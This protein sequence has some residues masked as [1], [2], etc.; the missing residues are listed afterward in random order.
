MLSHKFNDPSISP[1]V[2]PRSRTVVKRTNHGHV[3]KFASQKCARIVQ[4]ESSLE[5]DLAI[6]LEADP[7][8]ILFYEQPFELQIMLD[9]KIRTVYPDMMVFQDDG[10]TQVIEVKPSEKASQPKTRKKF[11]LEHQALVSMGYQFMVL[12]ENYI[13]NGFRL[14]NSRKLLPFR[15]IPVGTLLKETVWSALKWRPMS[16]KE[17]L[18]QINGLTFE[19]LFALVSHGV[20]STDLSVELTPQSLFSPVKRHSQ[21]TEQQK[22]IWQRRCV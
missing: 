14:P 17:M 4:L 9:D 16:A 12:T 20:I 8:V 10:S 7:S 5:Y 6:I 11:E 22:K 3:Y 21:L 18:Q 19:L 1:A 13:R 2:K 15:R